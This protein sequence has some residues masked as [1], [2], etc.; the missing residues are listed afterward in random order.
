MTNTRSS[1]MSAAARPASGVGRAQSQRRPAVP[2]AVLLPLRAVLGLSFAD[3]G[4]GKLLAPGWFGHGPQSLAAQARVFARGSP[5]HGLVTVVVLPHPV[6]FAFLI[7]TAELAVGLLTLAGLS[8]K[9]AAAT[10]LALSV[11]FFL[12]A[13]WHTRPFFYGADLPFAVGWLVLLRAGHGGLPSVDRWLAERQRA[14]AGLPPDDRLLAVRADRIQELCAASSPHGGCAAAVGLACRGASC[15]LALPSPSA[16]SASRR[17]FLQ[18]AAAAGA[19]LA[20]VGLLG[21]LTAAVGSVLGPRDSQAAPSAGTLPGPTAR[22]AGPPRTSASPGR[23]PRGVR[24]GSLTDVPVGQAA[25]FTDPRSGRPGIL[26]RLGPSRVVAYDAVCTHAGCTVGFDA[27]QHPAGMSLPRRR[28]RPRARRRRRGRPSSHAAAR[29]RRARHTRRRP[30]CHRL[31][32]TARE[33]RG[34]GPGGPD[35]STRSPRRWNATDP[36]SRRPTPRGRRPGAS[37]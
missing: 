27:G 29:H 12:T 30:V 32:V 18:R 23:V 20:G 14:D 5:L 10:G 25:V 37:P 9:L 13:S 2:A 24:I 8:S 34:W 31:V 7:A 1:S 35:S 11:S 19:T 33:A 17:A 21:G 22:S 15:P 16:A 3:A 28:V 4:V 6:L 26:V 36:P